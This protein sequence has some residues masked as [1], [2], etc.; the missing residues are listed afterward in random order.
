[1]KKIVD[2]KD[3]VLLYPVDVSQI[4]NAMLT[5]VCVFT[6]LVEMFKVPQHVYDFRGI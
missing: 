3:R 6:L 5:N 1:M 2:V 4:V